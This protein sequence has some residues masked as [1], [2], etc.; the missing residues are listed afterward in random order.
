MVKL[1]WLPR[2]TK[3][4]DMFEDSVTNLQA[5]VQALVDLFNHYENV[6]VKVMQLTELEHK[7]DT[8]THHIIEQL[9]RTFVTP[10]DREDISLLAYYLDEVRDFMEGAAVAMHLYHIEEPTS[11]TKEFATILTLQIEELAKAIPRL[12]RRSQMKGILEQCHEV[13]RLE[14]EADSIIRDALAELFENGLPATEIIKW[15]EI[16]EH[17]ETAADRAEDVANV[18]E[19]IVLKYG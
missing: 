18:L 15:R 5:T 12:R 10:L 13:K 19:G 8:I 14:K 4:F 3:F 2:E 16:Y 7:G 11:K 9:H 1:P 17:L 6:S